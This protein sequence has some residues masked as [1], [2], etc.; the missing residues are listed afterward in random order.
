MNLYGLKLDKKRRGQIVK[1]NN[2]KKQ[3]KKKETFKTAAELAVKKG[4]R[5]T[6]L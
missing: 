2:K 1:N 3:K 5:P 4:S 6:F